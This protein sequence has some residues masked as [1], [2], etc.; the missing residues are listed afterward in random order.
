MKYKID[1]LEVKSPD[2][3]II[4]ITGEGKQYNDVSVNKTSKKGEVFPNFDDMKAG[5]DI[6]GE[7]WVSQAGKNYLFPPRVDNKPQTRSAGA[8]TKAMDKKAEN[9][10]VA[11]GNKEHG[12]M[13]SSTI[14]M[15][16]D[17]ALAET[18]GL[19]FDVGVFKSRVREWRNWF[20]AEWDN[21]GQAQ[22]F[23]N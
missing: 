5:D 14:R 6:E 13:T 20:I 15:A 2:W 7:L 3:K 12:I 4:T 9:I 8:I 21:V 23:N 1:W 19:P 11:Q 17:I 16:V 22:P 18:T 10:A